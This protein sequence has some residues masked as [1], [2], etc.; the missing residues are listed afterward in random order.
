MENNWI[1]FNKKPVGQLINKC[2]EQS[3]KSQH[4]DDISYEF[5]IRILNGAVLE[6][7]KLQTEIN[8][9]KKNNEK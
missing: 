1:H 7:E 3:Y 5:I 8:E 4:K 6:I 9:L 2:T